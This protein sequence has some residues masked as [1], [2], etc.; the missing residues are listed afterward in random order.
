MN[1]NQIENLENNEKVVSKEESAE[2][3]G[4]KSFS[5]NVNDYFLKM[6]DIVLNFYL[7]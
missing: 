6:R 4:K 7:I 5:L 1:K 2:E 3:E